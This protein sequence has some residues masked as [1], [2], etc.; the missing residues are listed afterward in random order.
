MDSFNCNN[1]S[2]NLYSAIL[3]IKNGGQDNYKDIS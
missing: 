1:D 2:Y 3:N